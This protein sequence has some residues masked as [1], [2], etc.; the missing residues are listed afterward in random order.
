M[1]I[2]TLHKY[3]K[4]YPIAVAQVNKKMSDEMNEYVRFMMQVAERNIPKYVIDKNKVKT[5]AIEALRSTKVNDLAPIDGNTTGA[6]TP[7]QPT[8][9]SLENR[10]LLSIF[11]DQKN[12]L[13]SVSEPKLSG[14]SQTKFMGEL[15][16][17]E[18][19][20]EARQ[21][22]VQEGL[23]MLIKDELE[24]FK[25]IIVEFWDGQFFFKVTGGEKPEWYQPQLVQDPNDPS[26]QIVLNPLTELLTA[27]YFVNVDI[28]SA[29]RPNKER[30]KR[31]IVEFLNFLLNPNLLTFIQSQGKTLNIEEIKKVGREFGFN[32]ETLLIDFQPQPMPGVEGQPEEITPEEDARRQGEAERR[33]AAGQV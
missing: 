21:I 6:V 16:I 33:V 8:N 7:L 5:D 27:D 28:S 9:I 14:K 31:E 30:R 17:Q 19:G 1:K 2:G 29:L 18:A 22:D 10:E 15:Q 13:W 24:T 4:L 32:P 12:K 26:K 11:Q 3:G 25:D 23:R 20:F